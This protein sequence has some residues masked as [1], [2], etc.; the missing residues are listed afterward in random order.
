MIEDLGAFLYYKRHGP[1]KE[2]HEVGEEV[3]VG[4][5]YKLLDV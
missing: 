4:A 5:L 2:V 3:R 1:R